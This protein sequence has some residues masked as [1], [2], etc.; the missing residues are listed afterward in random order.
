[1]IEE[2]RK[3]QSV[4]VSDGKRESKGRAVRQMPRAV[5]AARRLCGEILIDPALT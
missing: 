5:W 3:T 1:V 2:S 4:K